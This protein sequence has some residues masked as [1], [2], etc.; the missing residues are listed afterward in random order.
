[1]IGLKR[2][3]GEGGCDPIA[4]GEYSV[5]NWWNK[6]E[7]DDLRDKCPCPTLILAGGGPNLALLGAVW[8][9]GFIVQRLTNLVF[10]AEQSTFIDDQI[11]RI[12]CFFT[13]IGKALSKLKEHYVQVSNDNDIPPPQIKHSASRFFPQVNK[14]KCRQTE[15]VIHFRYLNAINDSDPQN[16][17]F[18]VETTN[19]DNQRNLIVKFSDRYGF[20]AHEFLASQGYAPQLYYCGLI[21]GKTDVKDSIHACGLTRASAGGLYTGPVH[22][23]VMEYLTGKNGLQLPV[24]E[25]PANARENISAAIVCLHD[26]G[27]VFGDLRKPNIVFVGEKVN[28]VDF[29]WSGQA[30]FYPTALSHHVKWA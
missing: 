13:N 15:Q 27:F 6:P 3:L 26:G 10:M 9:D 30:V 11:Y 16:A 23:I 22:M 7:L 17:I 8:A 28:L 2:T 25:W 4:Q 29:D 5:L 18:L 21:D 12:A 14:F 19:E 1:M 24:E 20:D